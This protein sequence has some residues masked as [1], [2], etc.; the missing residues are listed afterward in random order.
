[1]LGG[2]F[3]SQEMCVHQLG[4]I[5]CSFAVFS[6]CKAL[7]NRHWLSC[8]VWHTGSVFRTRPDPAAI[9]TRAVAHPQT[10]QGPDIGRLSLKLQQQWDYEKNGH[11][12]NITVTPHTMRIV[13]WRCS[14]C[15][16]GHP[17]EW[18]AIVNQRTQND[19]CP[20]CRGRRVCKHSSLSTQA[21][22]VASSWDVEANAGTPDDYTA[23][24]RYRAHWMCPS[25]QHKWSATIDQ[26]VSDL[27]GCPQCF[28]TRRHLKRVMH[29]T[30]AACNHPLLSEWD[31]EANAQQGL[32]PEKIR[33]R[34]NKQVHWVCRKC[35]R[36]CMHR[37]QAAPN[38]RISGSRGCPSCSGHKACKCNSLQSLFPKVAQEW[39]YE[40]NEGSPDQYPSRC[41]A[42]VWWKSAERGSWQQSIHS[43]TQNKLKKYQ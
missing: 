18:E 10:Q 6:F 4:T 21:P 13:S 33:L 15:P 35:P 25:C 12:G 1:M 38:N 34:S 16:D 11:L 14:D 7:R 2:H 39:D 23:H 41:I 22:N 43:R 37:Y 3:N 17:H 28:K 31:F 40:R 24:S 20:F 29:P 8:D 42:I 19:G 30:L 26:R 9:C 5:I 32:H 36:G 27:T